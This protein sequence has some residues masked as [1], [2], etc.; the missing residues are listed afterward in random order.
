M[1]PTARKSSGN[2][3]I[4]SKQAA[5]LLGVRVQTI[6]AYVSRGLLERVGNTSRHT[7]SEF[8]LADV[9]ALAQRHRRQRT[10]TF[11]LSIDTSITYL[12]PSG[13]LLFRGHDAVDLAAHSTFEETAEL[14][15]QVP[16]GDWSAGPAARSIAARVAGASTSR[17]R[18]STR[19]RLACEIAS[20]TESLLALAGDDESRIPRALVVASVQSLLPAEPSPPDGAAGVAD[21]LWC[22]IAARR[23]RAGE[24]EALQ[25]ALVLLADHE[26]A[27]SSIAARAAASTGASVIDAV[28]AGLATMAGPRHGRASWAGEHLLDRS[29]RIGVAAT[30]DELDGAPAGFGHVVYREVDP[31]AEHLLD[32]LSTFSGSSVPIL[33]DLALEVYRRWQLVPNVDIA[34]A[35]MVHDL[36]LPSGSGELIFMVARMA[37]L[38]AHAL[39][40]RG[41]PMRFRPR[42]IYTGQQP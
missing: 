28:S 22:A 4:G 35:A 6:Y 10:G 36:G 23:P 8:R 39:E 26:L 27:T 11:E 12:D 1:S 29:T 14:L 9:Q 38:A 33:D 20:D 41:H 24:I 30:L 18:P 13:A 37:G 7:G 25:A 3:L 19:V 2:D 21:R 32:R 40:E 15:W 5:D 34:L 31:R 42:A 16:P 17:T